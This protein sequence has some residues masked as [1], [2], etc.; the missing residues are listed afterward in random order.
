[1]RLRSRSCTDANAG[2]QPSHHCEERQL[3]DSTSL[4]S[5]HTSS[6]AF[7]YSCW[8]R[9]RVSLYL[10]PG[11]LQARTARISLTSCKR[12]SNMAELI[13]KPA[14]EMSANS[15]S[16]REVEQVEGWQQGRDVCSTGVATSHDGSRTHA[17]QAIQGVA[18]EV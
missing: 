1:M 11:S 8:P 3:A 9:H 10:T 6:H 7:L 17:P 16:N 13:T 14:G 15:H 2:V 18:G 5:V 12:G 4:A